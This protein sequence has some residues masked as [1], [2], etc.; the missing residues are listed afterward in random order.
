MLNF[1][2]GAA[3]LFFVWVEVLILRGKG[4]AR[5][6]KVISFICFL[7]IELYYIMQLCNRLGL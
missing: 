3:M 6:E 1:F 2:I 5:T 7:F 4:L